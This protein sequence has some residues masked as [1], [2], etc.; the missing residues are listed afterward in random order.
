M[1]KPNTA[2]NW[3]ILVGLGWRGRQRRAWPD[4]AVV[5][6]PGPWSI[7]QGGS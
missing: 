4:A 5:R 1:I 6:R 3:R 7:F 2:K